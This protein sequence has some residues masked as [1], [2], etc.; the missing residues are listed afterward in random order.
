[1]ILPEFASVSILRI[2]LF[3]LKSGNPFQLHHPHVYNHQT[4]LLRQNP[5]C[6][7][8]LISTLH[9]K[10]VQLPL[11]LW[12]GS[13]GSQHESHQS[14]WGLPMVRNGMTQEARGENG[15][16]AKGWPSH[17]QSYQLSSPSWERWIVSSSGWLQQG[18]PQNGQQADTTETRSLGTHSRPLTIP[19]M[20]S[21]NHRVPHG[22]RPMC[23]LERSQ[24]RQIWKL[25]ASF[26][27]AIQV[28]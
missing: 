13:E 6:L 1:M 23:H 19:F 10:D 14:G 21:H 5:W 4:K 22:N 20:R 11:G 7:A 26:K 28:F 18:M 15:S 17:W 8:F 12:E 16:Q 2:F 25:R 24:D 27:R 3:P 9:Q